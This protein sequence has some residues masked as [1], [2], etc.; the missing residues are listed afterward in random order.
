MKRDAIDEED[1]AT[2]EL[3]AWFEK[4]TPRVSHPV[5]VGMLTSAAA[6]LSG[7]RDDA[8]TMCTRSFLTRHATSR[9]CPPCR[10]GKP[11]G[12]TPAHTIRNSV[13]GDPRPLPGVATCGSCKG[14]GVIGW[15]P[16]APT[17]RC[18]DCQGLGQVV[19][20][21]AALGKEQVEP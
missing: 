10:M 14:L 18:P 11:D 1:Q 3:I 17:P 16:G 7:L 5:L 6:Q 13:S 19:P 9:L 15:Q 4:F 20:A 12:W 2:D 21:S 8:C